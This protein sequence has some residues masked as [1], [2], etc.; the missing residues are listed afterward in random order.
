[1]TYSKTAIRI[2]DSAE[3]MARLG[4]YNGFSF[5]EIATEIGVK[6]ASVHYHFPN[7]EML[8]DALAERYTETFLKALG[9]P[10]DA[11]PTEM[12]KRYVMAYRRALKEDG[13]M[14]LCGIFGAEISDLP[15]AVARKTRAF[16]QRN[17][18]WLARVFAAQDLPT[19]LCRRKA[20]AMIATLEGA[21]IMAR[22]MQDDVLFDQISAELV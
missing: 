13:L 14:C 20:G 6:S 4:G 15:D 1:M 18:D 12:L 3:R 16:F 22:S 7:K 21:M 11:P 10:D 19:D 5:R 2:L 8:G 9:N 17:I